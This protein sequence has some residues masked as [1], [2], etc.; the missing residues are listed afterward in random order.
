MVREK[1]TGKGDG[2][3]N[4]IWNYLTVFET[5]NDPQAGSHQTYGMQ[6]SRKT[7]TG[8]KPVRFIHDITT[9]SQLA[10]QLEERFNLYQL[11]PVHLLDV[12]SDMLP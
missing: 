7:E 8:W 3:M 9:E 11:S 12:L 6:I 10:R 5:F 2:K 1:K 4:I